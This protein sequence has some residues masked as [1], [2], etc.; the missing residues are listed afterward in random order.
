MWQVIWFI[1]NILFVISLVV[2]LFVQR[3][4]T[5]AREEKDDARLQKAKRLRIVVGVV[6]IVLFAAM[7]GSFLTNMRL[8]GVE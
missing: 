1:I 2:Y 6:T 8:N 4:V 3:T 5:L 7:I